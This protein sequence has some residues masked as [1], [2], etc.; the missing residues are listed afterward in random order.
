VN[1]ERDATRE[2]CEVVVSDDGQRTTVRVRPGLSVARELQV[3]ALTALG[4][5]LDPRRAVLDQQLAILDRA[6]AQVRGARSSG[7]VA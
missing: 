5:G 1:Q 4:A 2:L 6:L 3:V 7:G